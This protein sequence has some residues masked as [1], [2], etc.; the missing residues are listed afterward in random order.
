[1]TDQPRT[2]GSPA[3]DEVDPDLAGLDE[4]DEAS[5]FDELRA[6]LAAAVTATVTLPVDGRPG[7]AVR[8]R[9]D[10]TGANVD[11]FR[12]RAKDRKFVDGVDGI[13]FAAILLASQAVAIVRRGKDVELEGKPA[14]FQSRDFMD[15]VG[16]SGAVD[17]VRKFYGLDGHVDAAA[18]ALM[19]EA[20]WGDEV[21]AADPT[22]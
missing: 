6:E 8:Y 13:K 4:L 12:K 21:S 10:F 19:V 1:M 11:A 16:G 17:T 9:A 3:L 5:D 15:L 20:G 2:F 18:R 22:D 14:T 7:W